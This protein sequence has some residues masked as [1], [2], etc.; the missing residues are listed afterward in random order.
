MT[1]H[2]VGFSGNISRPSKTKNLVEFV[3][4]AISDRKGCSYSVFDVID[5]GPSF[6]N[7]HRVQDLDG[8]AARIVE[9]I[10]SADVL[11][12]GSPTFKGSYTGLFK[13]FFDLLD[14]ASL[15]GKPV[16][17]TA[18]GG[19]DKHALIVEHQLRPLFG[20]FEALTLPTAIFASERDFAG[21]KL[22]G[23]A[24]RLRTEQAIEQAVNTLD[25]RRPVRSG[26]AA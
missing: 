17:V 15:R 12:V 24:V 14:P 13:H 2:I 20:F 21:G 9:Q 25:A 8:A 5:L 1:R 16:L 18:T 11:V 26:V 6:S 10:V 4:N 19:G 23:D 3:A 7:T 22:V